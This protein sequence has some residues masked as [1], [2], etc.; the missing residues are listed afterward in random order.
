[1]WRSFPFGGFINQ[2]VTAAAKAFGADE[3]TAQILGSGVAT[4]TGL[5]PGMQDNLMQGADLVGDLANTSENKNIQTAGQIA[6]PLTQVITGSIMANKKQPA[7]YGKG[8]PLIPNVTP[9][10]PQQLN[11]YAFNGIPSVNTGGKYGQEIQTNM[12]AGQLQNYVKSGQLQEG[13]YVNPVGQ[14]PQVGIIPNGIRPKFENPSDK[15]AFYQT[16]KNPAMINLMNQALPQIAKSFATGGELTTYDTGGTHEQNPIGGVPVGNNLVEQG[17]TRWEDYVF[18]NRL[19]V[20]GSKQ[21]FAQASKQVE[22]KFKDRPNDPFSKKSKDQMMRA[23]MKQQE[24]LKQQ[25]ALKAQKKLGGGG[26]LDKILARI[27][28]PRGPLDKPLATDE[29][30]WGVDIF[31]NGPS[32]DIKRPQI[33]MA[34]EENP[35]GSTYNMPNSQAGINAGLTSG[36]KENNEYQESPYNF[37]SKLSGAEYAAAFVPAVAGLA[38]GLS[39]AAKTSFDRVDPSF[40]DYDPQRQ[41]LQRQYNTAYKTANEN[42]RGNAST[43]GQALSSMIASNVALTNNL[44]DQMGSSFMNEA[45]M[46]SQIQNQA[47][48]ANANISMQE[49]IANEQNKARQ[50]EFL[51]GAL[52][53]AANSYLGLSKDKRAFDANN[54]F[55][56]QFL[57]TSASNEFIYDPITGTRY[58][59]PNYKK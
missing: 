28:T 42:I 56:N 13:Q 18:S 15:V 48:N 3:K 44:N 43:S 40:V 9:I 8:G 16:L 11:P 10:A 55:N 41:A 27:N 20:P 46:N 36:A 7:V 45:N 5:I 14:Q 25:M 24:E 17:E 57:K 47:N 58:K 2:G 30:P 50:Q 22:N 34:T 29:N 38:T 19:T 1:M 37:N 51:L 52:N 21:T 12:N 33:K 32:I 49:T 59:N 6:S 31:G 4:A 54:F 53:S 35:F 23:L 39:G 26:P